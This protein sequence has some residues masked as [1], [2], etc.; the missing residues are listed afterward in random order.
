MAANLIAKTE[1]TIHAP[2][3][4]VWQALTTPEMIKEY[5]FGTEVI[6]D[7]KVGRPLEFRGVWKGKEYVEKGTILKSD[8]EKLFQYNYLSSASGLED[9]PENYAN[10]TYELHEEDGVTTLTVRQENI[11][12]EEERIK[13]ETNWKTVMDNMK[14][15][16]EG[17][18]V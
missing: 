1:T 17:V 2:A 9:V 13:A 12:S 7:W 10:V 11:A 5:F 14:K 8:P 15:M 18:W 3:S 4:K 6:S 16:V